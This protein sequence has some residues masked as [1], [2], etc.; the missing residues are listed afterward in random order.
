MTSNCRLCG[1]KKAESE[2]VTTLNRE[3]ENVSFFELIQY[4]CRI[5]L[6]PNPL[7][8]QNVCRT[9]KVSLESFMLFCDHLERHQQILK[10]APRPKKENKTECIVI[11]DVEEKSAEEQNPALILNDYA[12]YVGNATAGISDEDIDSP[13]STNQTEDTVSLVNGYAESFT[14][15]SD[16][17]T[18]FNLRKKPTPSTLNCSVALEILDLIYIKSETESDSETE[19]NF[20]VAKNIRTSKRQRNSVDNVLE[21]N[22]SLAKRMRFNSFVDFKPVRKNNTNQV[23]I[24]HDLFLES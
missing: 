20:E 10:Q 8:S 23:L 7:L 6:D 1:H 4:F 24:T 5:E 16:S 19:S 9:C 17:T 14:S 21:G 15:T 12:A 18:H 2:F 3:T 11:Q 13:M 22:I